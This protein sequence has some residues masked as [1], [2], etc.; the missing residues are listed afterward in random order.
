MKNKKDDK[1]KAIQQMLEQIKAHE[2]ATNFKD[3]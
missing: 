3:K 1:S 2:S